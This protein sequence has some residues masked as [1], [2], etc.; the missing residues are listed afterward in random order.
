L[1]FPLYFDE[2]IN[3][4]AAVLLS[5]DGFDVMTTQGAGNRG[6]SDEHQLRFATSQGRAIVTYNNKDYELLA[7]IW[8]EKGERHCGIILGTFRPHRRVRDGLVL[9]QSRYPDGIEN[10]TLRLPSF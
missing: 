5:Q 9:I 10:L 1:S 2:H 4:L 3:P 8:A 6:L 7:R